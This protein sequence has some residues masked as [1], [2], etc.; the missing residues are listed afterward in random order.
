MTRHALVKWIYFQHFKPGLVNKVRQTLIARYALDPALTKH[1]QLELFIN[2]VYLGAV[3]GE[4]IHGLTR[5]ALAYYHKPVADLAEPEYLSLVAMINSPSGFD[6]RRR[7]AANTERV[8]RI[9]RLLAGDYR[10]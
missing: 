3:D 1:S 5:A 9:Q 10:P 4:P 7:P 6:L 8:R 2:T